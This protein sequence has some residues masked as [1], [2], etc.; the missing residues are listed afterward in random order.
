M[1]LEACLFQFLKGLA[2]NTP[3]TK[4]ENTYTQAHTH[5]P[6]PVF[7]VPASFA[8]LV[9]NFVLTKIPAY[10]ILCNS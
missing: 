3:N 8:S 10:S 5:T 7:K 6:P 9:N 2:S 4:V 1:R